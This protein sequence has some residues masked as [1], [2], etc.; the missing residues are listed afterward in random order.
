MKKFGNFTHKW[1][2]DLPWHMVDLRDWFYMVNVGFIEPIMFLHV[3]VAGIRSLW[4]F[5]LEPDRDAQLRIGADDAGQKSP[6]CNP[7]EHDWNEE[8]YGYKCLRCQL[9]Y[10]Y[11]SAPWDSVDE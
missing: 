4:E 8:Y 9:L 10:P 3:R 7:N 6:T 2:F 5:V 11:G 1:E